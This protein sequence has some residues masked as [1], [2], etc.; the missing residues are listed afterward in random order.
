MTRRT[1]FGLIAG[2]A[3]VLLAAL[4]GAA[5]FLVA[6]R[7]TAGVAAWGDAERAAGAEVRY[8]DVTVSGFPLRWQVTLDEASYRAP[9]PLGWSWAGAALTAEIRP[10]SWRQMPLR[11]PGRHQLSV[12]PSAPPVA[13]QAARPDGLAL[14]GPDGRLAEI[15]LDLGEVSVL[16]PADAAGTRIGRLRLGFAPG[17]QTHEIDIRGEE[18][19]LPR[20]AVA[21]FG[22]RIALAEIGAVL[23]GGV[24]PGHPMVALAAWRDQGGTLELRRI[25]VQWDRLDA[26]GDGTLALDDRMRPLAAFALR[27]RGGPETVDALTA[28]G[29]LRP[30][31]GTA[32]KIA[33]TALSRP[34]DNGG[35]AGARLPITIQDGR[36]YIAGFSVG[37]VQPLK[38]D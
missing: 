6:G 33:L 4:W 24:P 31:A 23:T 29:V 8:R 2:S 18:V 17:R 14:I 9:P 35:P 12:A 3:I 20:P 36:I 19:V 7:I 5:W 38:L 25:A 10:W 1:R 26:D 30:N 21:G 27:I 22:Q 16:E 15:S 34:A 11:F 28:A 37:T 13:L 32:L